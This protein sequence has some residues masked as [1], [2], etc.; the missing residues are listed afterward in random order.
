MRCISLPAG[1]NPRR[2]PPASRVVPA[3]SWRPRW[4][5]ALLVPL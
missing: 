4:W 1:I 3:S 2:R 5:K